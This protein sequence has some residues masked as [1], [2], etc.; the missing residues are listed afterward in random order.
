MLSNLLSLLLSSSLAPPLFPRR[1]LQTEAGRSQVSR[2][3]LERW[4][5][6]LMAGP[7]P[8]PLRPPAKSQSGCRPVLQVDA[9][10]FLLQLPARS[11][12]LILLT[13]FISRC[14]CECVAAVTLVYL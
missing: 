3:D 7:G 14:V 12:A 13:A 10:L 5:R 1:R 11:F 2:L 8:G 4:Y 6:E 9:S